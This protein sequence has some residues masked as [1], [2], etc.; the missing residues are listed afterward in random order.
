MAKFYG[1]ECGYG[2]HVTDSEGHRLG[3]VHVFD[4]KKQRD[5]W[6]DRDYTHRDSLTSS[7]ARK[8]MVND[9]DFDINRLEAVHNIL[10][11]ERKYAT[12]EQIVDCYR[13]YGEPVK[14]DDDER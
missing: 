11:S 14:G 7:E 4:T 5:D 1:I 10:W 3:T 12:I 13:P 6:E 2:K 9:G 8:Q